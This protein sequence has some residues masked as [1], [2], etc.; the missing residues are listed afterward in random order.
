MPTL[1]LVNIVNSRLASKLSP[2]NYVLLV[3]SYPSLTLSRSF[4]SP[5]FVHTFSLYHSIVT[6][7]SR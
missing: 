2:L 5:K 1:L 4:T 3:D 7:L 6:S